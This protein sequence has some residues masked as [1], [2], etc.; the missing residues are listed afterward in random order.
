MVMETQDE[1]LTQCQDITQYLVKQ[2]VIS[3]KERD[4]ALRI[5]MSEPVSVR[6]RFEIILLEDLRADRHR[7]MRSI[8]RYLCMEEVLADGYCSPERLNSI[9]SMVRDLPGEL[10]EEF[11][12][13]KALP[14]CRRGDT[15]MIACS[16]PNEPK[17]RRLVHYLPARRHI[18]V[19]CRLETINTIIGKVYEHRHEFLEIL[20]E[21]S[22]YQQYAFFR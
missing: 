19:Y 5:R 14:M 11:V 12:C 8:A 17:I 20:E 3:K 15:I 4:I 13:R 18:M 6:R 2:G 1:V 16:D 21:M 10:L 7:V 22:R 9:R